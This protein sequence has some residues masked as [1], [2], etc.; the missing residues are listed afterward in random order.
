VAADARV[1]GLTTWL[2][3]SGYQVYYSDIELGGRGR[4]RRVLA[5]AYTDVEAARVDA[6]HL[7]VEVAGLGA[8]VVDRA[9]AM[10]VNQ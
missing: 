9:S 5:G 3:S 7:N 2:Q 10:D 8:E 6:A 4:W 1:R